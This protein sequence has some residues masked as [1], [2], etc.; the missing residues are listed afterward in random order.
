MRQFIADV[1]NRE[2]GATAAEYVFLL[3]FVAIVVS[4]AMATLGDNIST[5]F[6]T[7]GTEV[8]TTPVGDA[9]N[10]G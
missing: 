10:N 5:L 3:I 6:T 4:V 9:G 1:H 2:E 8:S 7:T